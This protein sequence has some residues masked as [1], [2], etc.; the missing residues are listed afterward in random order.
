MSN[1]I[2]FYQK[3][4]NITE[5]SKLCGVTPRTL[6]Y[7]EEL[8]LFRPYSVNPD[9]GYRIYTLGQVDKISA[10]RLLQ[11]HGFTLKEIRDLPRQ[12]SFD[13]I[14]SHLTEQQTL[15][16]QRMEELIQQKHYVDHT[17]AHM[18]VA[19]NYMDQ[20]IMD[21]SFSMGVVFTPVKPGSHLL[22]NFLSAGYQNGSILNA[23]TFQLLGIYQDEMD[24][25]F[26]TN[27]APGSDHRIFSG[28]RLCI[29]HAKAP[30]ESKKLLEKLKKRALEE[31]IQ[32]SHIF[33]EQIL[34][35]IDSSGLFLYY[36]IDSP[37]ID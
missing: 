5:F 34:E 4:Y 29:Y 27:V 23:D 19:R 9:N 22:I 12:T 24:Q 11:E 28:R 20:F 32:S 37:T 8:G 15:I 16:T 14:F 2:P 30:H 3:K 18:K 7:Y 35:G 25:R 1:S 6:K 10:I 31:H 17:L 26:S 13:D 33:C 21:E 36:M